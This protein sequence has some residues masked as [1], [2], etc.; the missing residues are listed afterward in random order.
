MKTETMHYILDDVFK[1]VFFKLRHK[2]TLHITIGA[3]LEH[4]LDTLKEV[5]RYDW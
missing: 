1:T 3:L 4:F 2:Q 5:L